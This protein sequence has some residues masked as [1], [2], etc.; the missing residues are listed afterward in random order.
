MHVFVG[1]LSSFVMTL[2][3]IQ[4]SGKNAA[5]VML[6]SCSTSCLEHAVS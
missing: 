4:G 5:L 3:W 6:K 1:V 2:L